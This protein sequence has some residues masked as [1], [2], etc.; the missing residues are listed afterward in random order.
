[1]AEKLTPQQALAVHDR[2]GRLLVSAAAGSGKT[3]V[4]VDRLMAYLTDPRDPADLDEFLMITYTK[5]AASEL[6]G[7]IAAKLTE[8]MAQEPA[9][10]RLQRQMQRLYLTKIST[11]HGFCAD[12]L[13]EYA[14]R[15]DLAA[16]FRVADENECRE[17]RERVMNRILEDAY[18]SAETDEDFRL[19]V[20][21]QG[22][23]RD[24]RLVP[25]I[26]LQVYDSARCHL[27]PGGW[28][29]MC[30]ANAAVENVADAGQTVWGR[31]LMEDLFSYLDLQIG[32]MERC[33]EA[34][35]IADG[36]EKP[37]ALLRDTVYQ[38]RHLRESAC[39][40]EVIA[41][42]NIDYGRM[43]IPKK[44][45]DQELGGQIK[46]VR[47]A[48][49]KG[50]EK[51]L[52]SFAADTA[53]TLGDMTLCAGAAK[54]MAALVRRF[55]AEYDRQKRLRRVL[56]FG[57][58]E[59][60]TLDL[61]LGVRREGPTAA[62][63]EIG[64][65][66]REIMVDEYQ[67]SNA[68]Q[69]AVFSALTQKRQNCFMVGDVKQSIYQFRLADP[70]IFLEKYAAY[71]PAEEARPGQGRKVTLSCNFRSCGAVLEGA[72]DIFRT[73]MSPEVGGLWY[74]EEEALR[75]GLPHEP[76]GEPEVELLALDVQ[77]STYEE[78][79][80]LTARRICQLLDGSHY[81]RD[82]E[83]LRPIRPEDIAIL[84][85][86]PGSLG[87][88][89]RAALEGCGVR[90]T[91]GGGDD[92]LQT[93]EVAAIRALLQA[94]R[95]PR[96]DIPL[97]AAMVSPVFGFTADELADFRSRDR[98]GCVYDALCASDLPKAK[99]FL[100]TLAQ[101][102]QDA[103]MDTLASLMEKI[104]ALTRMD[105]IYAA[106]EG[107]DVRLANLQAF[108]SLAVEFEAAGRR[109]L[110]QFL[111]SL[112][113]M[114]EKGLVAAGEQ[115]AAGAVTI[116]S[117]HKSKGLEFPV[118]FVCGLAREFNRESARGQVL[119]D[120][121]LGMGLTA[122]DHRNRVRYPTLA[123]RAIAVKTQ[124]DGL[125]EEMRVLYVALTRA[126]D[127]LI[128]TYAVKNLEN[129]LSSMALRMDLSDMRLLT[130][131]AVCPGEWVMLA[132]LRRTEAG[133]LFALSGRP[134][135]TCGSVHPWQIRVEEAQPGLCAPAAGTEEK[136]ETD[137]ALLRT[138]EEGLAF[139]YAHM[140]ATAA[141]SKQTAT[142]RKGR[143]KDAEAAEDTRPVRSAEDTWR[144]PAF[145]GPVDSGAA[146]GSATHLCMQYI[147][148]D[149]CGSVPE[150]EREIRRLTDEGFLTPEQGRMVDSA[151]IAAFF[152]TEL[153][154]KLRTAPNVLREFKFSI[155]DDGR[156]FA[157]DLEGE[158][159]LL[160]GVV[161][162]ALIDEDGITVLD[163]KTDRVTRET[164]PG[165]AAQYRP[166]I[167]AYAGALER[168][169]RKPVKAA[170][171]YFFRLGCFVPVE[172]YST[173]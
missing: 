33:A 150:V 142:Q 104:F 119:C 91:T 110:G 35:E 3:K 72:N 103:R 155:L 87:G 11:V 70:S 136:K 51:K 60:K 118:V 9:N 173:V 2:G 114:R 95:N 170:L 141:P 64:A 153:G 108:Y 73:C 147:R 166:Q 23:G 151:G 172:G 53:Q 101:L 80:A 156:N 81:V 7:K 160:Q 123:K 58:L 12:I 67:D 131:D 163:F 42:K 96:Q 30:V 100:A 133:E 113:A 13:R 36:M 157:P 1:M 85:R 161:D 152:A 19:F 159:I 44:A 137:D 111:Q 143:E 34:A 109:D 78:E 121:E 82:G 17:L 145:A 62:A 5:A 90:C 126:R 25:E 167:T 116:M 105:S 124:A 41:R 59:H 54:G 76:L 92:L 83:G 57:D 14:Y 107:G 122:V 144:A 50:M 52:K 55:A 88:A 79:A 165:R 125:S 146:A 45:P 106:M 69:D 154:K 8:R 21:T 112:D 98:R 31:Y 4:L 28:L 29:D 97:I 68:V 127:R 49:K 128:M 39:W 86:S 171:L 168:I 99:A 115:S 20:D 148:Y 89:F 117:I 38:L 75:E 15:L 40:D 77:Q 138:L 18:A 84:L 94:I 140:A 134:G 162:C 158:Q 139:R 37:A 10:H 61:L 71:V 63:G 6:R 129:D 135:Q 46:A 93:P 32:A 22:L 65:R 47:D 26:L 24:D 120:K 74:G 102:R 149:A 169:Y 43:V 130:R 56:D 164:L 48:C 27:D 66:F 16:D 132:A